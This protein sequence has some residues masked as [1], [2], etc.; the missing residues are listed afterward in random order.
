LQR[1]FAN[2]NKLAM[3][4]TLPTRREFLQTAS[5][6]VT[7]SGSGF[8]LGRTVL[9]ADAPATPT[10]EFRQAVACTRREAGEAARDVLLQGGNAVDAAIAALM[11]LCVIDPGKVSFGGYGGSMVV[12]RAKSGRVDA[13][14]FTSRAPQG[15]DPKRLTKANQTLGWLSITVPAIFAG[16]ETALKKHGSMPFTKLAEPAVSL[17]EKGIIVSPYLALSFGRLARMDAASR[18]AFFPQ[19][20]PAQGTVWKQPDVARLLRRLGD[21]GLRSFY[22]GDIA[23][24]IVKQVQSAGGVLSEADFRDTKASSVDPLHV[25]YCGHDLFTSPPPAGGL[26]TLSI[27]KTLEQFDPSKMGA[28]D[29]TYIDLFTGAARQ[30]W[31]ER[32]QYFGDPDFV[33]IPIDTLLSK[34]RAIERAH[35]LRQGVGAT[36]QLND[37]PSH[38]INV[39]VVD[40]D[41]NMVSLTATMGEE[42]GAHVV[43][44]GLGLIL[45]HGMSRFTLVKSH[46]NYP[47]PG[48]RPQ[49][50]MS[51]MLILRDKQPVG[52][53]GMPGGLRIVTVTGQVAMNLINFG[54]TPQ[55]AVAAPR[56]HTDGEGPIKVGMD[57]PASTVEA[58]K[59]QGYSVELM[60]PIGGDANTVVIHPRADSVSAA[61]SKSSTGVL[62]F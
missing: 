29:P 28:V 42:F 11:V 40:L 12:Y 45:S 18:K 33:K 9:G 52:A 30:C 32:E 25:E 24:S 36:S 31:A 10:E 43:V 48:K 34:E 50:N 16:I 60:D 22:T 26:T 23:A 20:V 27:L 62:V 8:T 35:K 51:P 7:I 54:M 13:I 4:H 1:E 6:A 49:H 5:A 14:D 61:A 57:M 38:T 15:L 53:I 37:G 46:P 39:V 59:K 21:E 55:D 56:F 19:G 58:L 41:R 17:A 44:N 3:N 2:H 47:E